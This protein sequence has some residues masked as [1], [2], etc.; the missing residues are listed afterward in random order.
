[1]EKA[2]VSMTDGMSLAHRVAKL[3]LLAAQGQLKQGENKECNLVD[4]PSTKQ[5]SEEEKP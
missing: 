2:N 1:M 5:P 4:V 3:L